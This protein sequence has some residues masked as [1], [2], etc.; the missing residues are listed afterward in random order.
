MVPDNNKFRFDILIYIYDSYELYVKKLKK[1]KKMEK[2]CGIYY[3]D[4]FILL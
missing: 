1:I 2:L 3:T 4:S